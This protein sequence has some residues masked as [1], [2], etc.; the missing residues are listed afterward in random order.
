MKDWQ[1][2]VLVLLVV[3]GIGAVVYFATRRSSPDDGD[4]DGDGTMASNSTADTIE[5][6]G[7][8]GVGLAAG[9]ARLAT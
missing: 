6:F 2:V 9:I 7:N 1:I 8:V 3:V 4:S 5:G